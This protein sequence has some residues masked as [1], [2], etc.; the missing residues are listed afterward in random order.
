MATMVANT[1]GGD[2]WT[3]ADEARALGLTAS[4]ISRYRADATRGHP[5]WG[6][7]RTERTVWRQTYVLA[8]AV[9]IIAW[10]LVETTRPRRGRQLP[11]ETVTRVQALAAEHGITAP[12]ST[13]RAPEPTSEGEPHHVPSVSASTRHDAP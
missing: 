5:V 7:A 10:W 4:T 6:P 11:A 9:D 1:V 13:G 8:P 2:L 12:R 3:G